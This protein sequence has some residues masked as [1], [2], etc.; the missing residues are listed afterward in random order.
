MVSRTFSPTLEECN[1]LTFVFFRHDPR[2]LSCRDRR[3]DQ[4]GILYD[5]KG[6]HRSRA[7]AGQGTRLGEVGGCCCKCTFSYSALGPFTDIPSPSIDTRAM[8]CYVPAFSALASVLEI[9]NLSRRVRGNARIQ[10]SELLCAHYEVNLLASLIEEEKFRFPDSE[11]ELLLYAKT[12]SH[13]RLLCLQHQAYLWRRNQSYLR[14]HRSLETS[15][16]SSTAIRS[17]LGRWFP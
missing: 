12:M 2:R 17:S 15:A 1:Q 14:Q 8:I 3:Q 16:R 5:R 4:R 9:Q 11:A 13:V 6:I 7:K 10:D